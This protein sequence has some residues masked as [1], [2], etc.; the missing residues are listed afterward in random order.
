MPTLLPRNDIVTKY[1]DNIFVSFYLCTRLCKVS[2]FEIENGTCLWSDHRPTPEMC[3][4]SV[5]LTKDPCLLYLQCFFLSR[6][7]FRLCS[8]SLSFSSLNLLSAS[9][10]SVIV[11]VTCFCFSIHVPLSISRGMVWIIRLE[12]HLL[13][14]EYY[15]LHILANINCECIFVRN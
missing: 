13:L 11:M 5:S 9:I 1:S 2:W 8:F 4:E 15:N 10:Q 12:K 3:S 7:I 14:S 6:N